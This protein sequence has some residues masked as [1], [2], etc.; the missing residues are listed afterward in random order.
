MSTSIS[1]LKSIGHINVV[2]F[3]LYIID[4]FSF[5]YVF[6]ALLI[7][8]SLLDKSLLAKLDSNFVLLFLFSV[9]YA[10]F[11]IFNL[12]LG[13]QFIFIYAFFP[14]CFYLLGKSFY[15]PEAKSMDIF[16]FIFFMGFFFSLP[17][18]ISI[19]LIISTDGF[20]TLERDVALIWGK[21]AIP[22]T[23]MAAYFVLNM[24]IPAFLV[25][26]FKKFTLFYK[27]LLI[28]TFII[29]IICLL[30]LG[31][32]T[33]LSIFFITFFITLI[34]L[35]YKQTMKQNL[36]LFSFIFLIF[37]LFLSYVSFS[38]DS[39]IMSAFTGRMDSK[40][41]GAATAGGRT[42]RWSK[43][44]INLWEEPVGWPLDEFGFSHNLWFDIAR[45]GGTLSF[46]LLLLFTVNNLFKIKNAVTINSKNVLLNIMFICYGLSFYLL[47][48][49]EP[50][51]DG[52][53]PVFVLYCFF[54]G[55]ISQYTLVQRK[56]NLG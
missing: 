18:I 38:K 9:T 4:P 29:T 5:G 14:S 16:K 1:Y 56:T 23:N 45:V 44:F 33:Q 30:R 13:V 47:F 27:L 41:Y 10:T 25:A 19:L 50:I 49:V 26:Y 53:F 36:V 3:F 42:E 24:S 40:K 46:L 48:F 55:F 20:V 22:A 28:I 6:G 52:Y 32:R 8:N 11:Y 12:G 31:S 35:F 39:D 17:S 43:S 7:I 51:F 2:L 34:Y 21:N 15:T 37:N 54:I